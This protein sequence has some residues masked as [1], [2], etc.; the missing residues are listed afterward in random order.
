MTAHPR[1]VRRAALAILIL[2]AGL[3]LGVIAALAS[4]ATGG[5]GLAASAVPG[6]LPASCAP[7]SA[8][9]DTVT[10][11][12]AA[13]AAKPVLLGVNSAGDLW[14]DPVDHGT[15]NYTGFVECDSTALSSLTFAWATGTTGSGDFV[16]FDES[17][18]TDGLVASDSTETQPITNCISI[19]GTV[20]PS[21]SD[22]TQVTVWN[23][24]AGEVEVGNT[25]IDFNPTACTTGANLPSGIAGFTLIGQGA[26]TL[27]T[28]G[29]GTSTTP[30]F[31]PTTFTL[32][33]PGSNATENIV[34]GD[35]G[36]S[37]LDFSGVGS[38][39][40]CGSSCALY[41]NS[42]GSTQTTLPDGTAYPLG[43]GSISKDVAQLSVPGPVTETWNFSTS[44]SSGTSSAPN[45]FNYD[46]PASTP[47]DF[48]GQSGTYPFSSLPNSSEVAALGSSASTYGTS[49]ALINAQNCQF[50][51]GSA[52]NTFYVSGGSNTFYASSVPATGTDNFYDTGSGNTVDFTGVT[53]SGAQQLVINAS[54]VPE[55]ISN[56]S[57]AVGNG[58]ATWQFLDGPGKS[59][60]KNFTT[61][62]GSSDGDT[63]FIAGD[64]TGLNFVGTGTTNSATFDSSQGIV[65]NFG[66]AAVNKPAGFTGFQLS[67]GGTRVSPV[68]NP[69]QVYVG[70]TPGGLDNITNV[71][72]VTG[73][74]AGF[75]YFYAGTGNT[76]FTFTGEGT[77]TTGGN[78]WFF[79]DTSGAS[80]PVSFTSG[81][82]NNHF[83]AGN[84]IET[85]SETTSTQTPTNTIDF[86]N[87]TLP[88][89]SHLVINV[90]GVNTTVP[91]FGAGVVTNGNLSTTQVYSFGT[92][93]T[94]FNILVGDTGGNTTFIG[95]SGDYQYQGNGTASTNTL[96]FSDVPTATAN[97]LTLDTTQSTVNLGGVPEG[98]SGISYLI[99]L[100]NGNTTFVG[101]GTGGFTFQGNGVGNEAA[102][103]T[104]SI[105]NLT[106][107]TITYNVANNCSIG[108]N[109]AILG[110]TSTSCVAPLPVDQMIDISNIAGQPSGPASFYIYAGS[111]N[112]TFSDSGSSKSDT[113][114]FTYVSTSPL[115]PLILDVSGG[116]SSG[117]AKVGT[118]T[119]TFTSGTA[120][121]TTFIGPSTGNTQYLASPN[122]GYTYDAS[123]TGDSI[124][125]SAA[126]HGVTV[127][128][129]GCS[130][131]NQGCVVIN[132]G[133]DFINGLTTVTGSAQGGNTFTAG[134]GPTNYTFTGNGN[135][136]TFIGPGSASSGTDT[137]ISSGNNNKF[138]AGQS[139]ENFND[140]GTGNTVDLSQ[141][142]SGV[143]ATVNV[144]GGSPIGSVAT[145]T[146]AANG[147][148]YNFTS[149]G[150]NPTT[151]Y[152]SPGGTSFFAGSAADTFEGAP[153]GT[154]TLSFA[155]V[156]GSTLTLTVGSQLGCLAFATPMSNSDASYGSAQL[157]SVGENFCGITFL[158]GLTSGSTTFVAAV[159]GSPAGGYHFVG[160]G[161]GNSVDFSQST[162]AIVANLLTNQVTFSGLTDFLTNVSTVTGASADGNR[163]IAGTSP[164]ETFLAAPN[165]HNNIIDFS[166]VPTSS[167]TSLVI[168]VS[169]GPVNSQANGTAVA[170][171]FNYT[172]T[173]TNGAFTQFIG[174]TNGNTDFL[175]NADTGHFLYV[176]TAA[177]GTPGNLVDFSNV[178]FPITVDL[179]SSSGFAV[180]S[181]GSSEALLNNLTTVIGS[182]VGGDTFIS[183]SSTYKFT[184]TGG[185]NTFDVGSGAVSITDPAAGNTI[186]F[187]NAAVGSLE[188][189]VSGGTV[190]TLGNDIARV[191]STTYSFSNE[192]TT[193]FASG[194]GPTVFDAGAVGADVFNG[195]GAIGGTSTPAT[196][197]FTNLP[198]TV[199]S[200]TIC[201]VAN[202]ANTC[203]AGQIVL[204]SVKE[205]FS[206]IT[207]FDGLATGSTTFVAGSTQGGYVFNG[208][209]SN[210]VADF[211]RVSGNLAANL[212]L[213]PTAES[214]TN[215]PNFIFGAG[216]D[217][218]A[219][220][221]TVIGSNSGNTYFYAGTAN[222]TFK[223]PGTGHTDTVD[224]SAVP[225]SGGSQLIINVSGASS[226][227]V[228]SDTAQG[229]GFTYNFGTGS[230][231]FTSFVGSSQ[232]NTRFIAARQSGGYTFQGQSGNN[233]ADFSA[234]TVGIVANM[235]PDPVASLLSGQVIVGGT[236]T[237]TDNVS[238]V[239]FL[240]GSPV[241]AN[242]FYGGLSGIEFESTSGLNTVSYLGS[243]SPVYFNVP[244]STVD[245]LVAGQPV[246]SVFDTYNLP[247]SLIIQGSSGTDVFRV[248]TQS[249]QIE[250]GGTAADIIDLG[251]LNG[252]TV[253]MNTGSITGPGMLGTSW[254]LSCSP[255]PSCGLHVGTILGSA[256]NDTY[257]LSSTAL[258]GGSSGLNIV[259]NRNTNNTLDLSNIGS[260]LPYSTQDLSAVVHMPIGS[261]NGSV[262][263][264]VLNSPTLVI[265]G[266]NN[267][268]GTFGGGDYVYAGTGTESFNE[269]GSTATLDFSN[270]PK[271][272]GSY[273]GVT[274]SA[275]DS[276]GVFQGT[277]STPAQVGLQQATF[278]G[279]NTF[280]GT[281]GND[282]FTQSGNSPSNG[283]RFLA[284]GG[285]NSV[286]LS[287]GESGTTIT[288]TTPNASSMTD[289]VNDNCTLS[290][291]NNDGQVVASDGTT[292]VDVFSCV[293]NIT[294]SGSTFLVSPS[295][296]TA[297]T[298]TVI[299]GGGTGTLELINAPSGQGATINLQSGTVS[300]VAGY[301]VTFTGMSTVFGTQFNDTFLDGS[302]SVALVG[303]GGSDAISFAG[304]PA[305]AEVNLSSVPYLIPTGYSGAGTDLASD[306]ASGGFGGVLSL[307]GISNVIGTTNFNDL[308]VGPSSGIGSMI[309]GSGNERFVLTGGFEYITAGAGG[310]TL[311]LSLLPGQTSL[312]LAASGPQYLGA[313]L[314][315]GVW[316]LSG[317]VT[318]IV[319]S[320]GGSSLL[321]GVGTLTLQGGSGNDTL[322][323]GTGTQTLNGGGGSDV[324]IGGVGTDSLNG[325]SAPVT[326]EP[327]SGSDTLTSQTTGNTLN[328]QGAPNAVAV[329]LTSSQQTVPPG[330]P[331]FSGST[332]APQTA[333]GG[334]GATV[335]LGSA[336]ITN[337]L[338]TSLSD[339]IAV[340]NGDTVTGGGG[341]DLFLVDGGGNNLTAGNNTASVF[342][343]EAGGSNIINGG[344]RSTVDY[345]EGTVGVKVDLQNGQST[346]GFAVSSNNQLSGILN[347]IGTT[348][349][350]LLIA[351]GSGATIIGNGANNC[352]TNC[353]D[354]LQAGP[355][356]GDVL[357]SNPAGNASG[358]DTFC[359]MSSC[360]TTGT[361][362]GGGDTM[363]GGTGNDTFFTQNGVGDAINGEGG[364]NYALVDPNDNRT[365]INQLL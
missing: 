155:D 280:I 7:T 166:V 305:A 164:S 65:A 77:T 80:A 244:T 327:G 262:V 36:A 10:L 159:T 79:A 150:S 40:G 279:F 31:L 162:T 142:G 25:T 82:E 66:T 28:G 113:I 49:T 5:R 107:Q 91:D 269:S 192:P 217:T 26:D 181:G 51:T 67:A 312:N 291:A 2:G 55:G 357:E 332:I 116:P 352:A 104:S 170:G 248:G 172:F 111:A 86:S 24:P 108:S 149:F 177:A 235:S 11:T 254:A 13:S 351:G 285:S 234:N 130:G 321:G 353:G 246:T 101:G 174:A 213:D 123:A 124:D 110:L 326:F 21:G 253:N 230:S 60:D 259:A 74:S 128:Y 322:V 346:G 194:S 32:A 210:N 342:L 354:V 281:N 218:V 340:G 349:N 102:F 208:F 42:S 53:T 363:I 85:F 95:G 220:I 1:R 309:G 147:Y 195:Q 189:N 94:Q 241:A 295:A 20:A 224:F 226:S 311:D 23:S 364:Y 310:S 71:E 207:T 196:L 109:Q 256:G 294:S 333:S 212:A 136:N 41:V 126:S 120:N 266:I 316:I 54:G 334:W 157:G 134:T 84:G 324:L 183:G 361:T 236:G 35:S 96:D 292:V 144:T 78:N 122:F 125:F 6:I 255:A 52:A 315:G 151:F 362:A 190:G 156:S 43:A 59:S 261:S 98:F 298:N 317:N 237:T 62:N 9:H 112:E 61:F 358:N 173:G 335:S 175:A 12:G 167:S 345:S 161:T 132:G 286:N 348:Y 37:T 169:G 199:G 8:G 27:S 238:D 325:G 329:N 133:N 197:D 48:W 344:G 138:T 57:A 290:V 365:N 247:G 75:S 47:V 302:S 211:S 88:G 245:E 73:P 188:V 314:D 274:V 209:G 58:S 343:F 187:V 299:N 206:G 135:G 303:N 76:S 318:Q 267:V 145:D 263:G 225:T 283:Y 127:T 193:F 119:Y 268:I 64:T 339:L 359:A 14:I 72:T 152:G 63:E 307:T 249:T 103:T 4:L 15:G 239:S 44:A 114:D 355:T 148:T 360:A 17:N 323:A 278:T 160:S 81:G 264:T 137:F 270:L 330:K 153:T 288:L 272:S 34:V 233:T 46:F 228:A 341:N 89:T 97:V 293:G 205:S 186:N 143:T 227:G 176:F 129:T 182:S 87:V 185:N 139:N 304:A 19:G 178:A 105:V 33:D 289:G 242:T 70:G 93:G 92:G 221:T 260:A 83:V 99:G 287:A 198:G 154:N 118:T 3:V 158:D 229:D 277:A 297:T 296:S 273:T 191:G 347:I 276:A 200:L 265:S 29:T 18:G 141:L 203:S 131:G 202:L 22:T 30:S 356:G 216:S 250:G 56:G 90:S 338:G 223:D 121:F 163:F 319:A 313:P 336:G 222:D 271:P 328:Y 282:S 308:L 168:N 38:A 171:Q 252:A 165:S 251:A 146:A 243:N 320:P 68:V 45:V 215:V 140:S 204:G 219:G 201:T 179:P 257:I 350:D 117:T 231:N 306:T 284:G 184:T 100:K 300:G 275:V 115:L 301:K 232:G 39:F 258:D 331:S 180:W 106:S 337:L 16:A 214:L 69:N 50:F 240:I